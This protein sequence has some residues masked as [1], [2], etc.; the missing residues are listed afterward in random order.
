MNIVIYQKTDFIKYVCVFIVVWLYF[1][2]S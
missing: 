2:Q 1:R